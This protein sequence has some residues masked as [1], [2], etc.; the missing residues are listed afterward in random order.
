MC[1]IIKQEPGHVIPLHTDKYFYFSN[2][3]YK[4][5]PDDIV[6]FAIFLED[7]QSGH[8]FELAN[9]PIVNWKKGQYVELNNRLPHRSGN[10][11]DTTKYTAQITGLLK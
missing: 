2:K 9:K 10:I 6:R 3:T 4:C 1:S 8:Y 11:G 7:W 5:N